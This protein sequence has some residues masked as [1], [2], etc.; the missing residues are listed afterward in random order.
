MNMTWPESQPIADHAAP[1]DPPQGSRPDYPT[2]G[3]L[4]DAYSQAVIGVVRR[5]GPAVI[6]VSG[7]NGADGGSGSGF[8][9]TPDGFALTNSHVVHGRDHLNATTEEGD[10]LD[11]TLI[12]D[13]PATDLALIRV[14]ARDLPYLDLGVGDEPQVGQLVIAVG[15]PFGFRST[16]STGVVSALGRS[17]RSLEG[18]LIEDIVQHT[19]PLNP[20]NSGGPLVDSRGRLVGVNTAIIAFAQGLG[21]AVPGK[22]ARW[23]ATEL[24]AHGHVHRLSLGIKAGVTEIPRAMARRLDILNESAVEV[25]EVIKGSA[26]ETAGI[27]PGDRIITAAGRLTSGID[28]LHRVLAAVPPEKGLSMEVI[29]NGRRMELTVTPR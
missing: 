13:D 17:M 5:V 29:R 27:R 16:V 24:L 18:R 4:L 21:F 1:I 20:G 25:V 14:E 2:D 19:A 26:A 9:V 10:S 8:L 7:K 23:F 15:N 12:G 28:D 3:E 22:T 11:A 6:T